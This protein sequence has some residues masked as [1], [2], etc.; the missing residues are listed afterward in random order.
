LADQVNA[1]DPASA[2]K[3]A[4]RLARPFIRLP[5]LTPAEIEAAKAEAAQGI[6]VG[7]AIWRAKR[8][9]ARDLQDAV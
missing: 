2:L 3:A 7:T 8:N 9:K 5:E 6:P 4:Y 1:A